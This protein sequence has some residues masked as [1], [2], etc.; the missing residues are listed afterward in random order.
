[1]VRRTGRSGGSGVR[2]RL[3]KATAARN[4]LLAPIEPS[5]G[6][7]W[8]RER[9]HNLDARVGDVVKAHPRVFRQAPLQKLADPPGRPSGKGSPAG[10]GLEDLREGV[11]NPRRGKARAR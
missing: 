6:V 2:V 11:G 7:R 9:L 10:L 8:L 1:M 5:P 4:G 3:H